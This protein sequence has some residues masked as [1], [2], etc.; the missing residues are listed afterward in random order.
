MRLHS[1]YS[2][3]I[4]RVLQAVGYDETALESLVAMSGAREAELSAGPRSNSE[5]GELKVQISLTS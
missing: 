4:A 1:R 5:F 2:C 3:H